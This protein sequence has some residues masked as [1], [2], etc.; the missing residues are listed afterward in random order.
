VTAFVSGHTD[1]ADWLFLIGAICAGLASL[2]M[3]TARPDPSRGALFPAALALV[4]IG[5]LVL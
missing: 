4:A 2:L 3:L 5:L 1:L